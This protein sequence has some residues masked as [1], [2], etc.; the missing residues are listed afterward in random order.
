[1]LVLICMSSI[2]NQ[3]EIIYSKKNNNINNDN[4]IQK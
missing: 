2:V 3:R 1:M 4:Y